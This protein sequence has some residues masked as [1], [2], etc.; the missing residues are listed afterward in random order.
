LPTSGKLSS[1]STL[2]MSVETRK[3]PVTLT[4]GERRVITLTR[5]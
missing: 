1:D 5:R 4:L 2:V 3:S